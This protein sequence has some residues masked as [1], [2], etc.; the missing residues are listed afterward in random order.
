MNQINL[1]GKLGRDPEFKET[2]GGKTL[3]LF[4]LAVDGYKKGETDWFECEAWGKTAEIIGDWV[5]KGNQVRVTGRMRYETWKDK[6]T[7]KKRS[8]HVVVVSEVGLLNN[9][10]AA[11][12]TK[13]T[14]E[15]KPAD[16]L[17][18]IFASDEE[19]PF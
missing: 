4:S 11:S 3:A 18:A 10:T 14:K 2:S 6:D 15:T 13:G 9:G 16:D 8:K 5:R 7:E 19:L 1:I 12:A 17:D